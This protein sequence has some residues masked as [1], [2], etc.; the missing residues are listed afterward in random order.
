MHGE[1]QGKKMNIQK[2]MKFESLDAILVGK[3]RGDAGPKG[4]ST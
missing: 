2:E 4:E 3:G 1:S